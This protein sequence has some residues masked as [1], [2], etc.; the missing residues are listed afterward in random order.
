MGRQAIVSPPMLPDSIIILSSP[1][2]WSRLLPFLVQSEIS[3]PEKEA[4]R[5]GLLWVASRAF[6]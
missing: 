3:T 2:I 5:D 4:A 1:S 6:L